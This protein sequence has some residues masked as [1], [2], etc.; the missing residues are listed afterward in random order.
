MYNN[1]QKENISK[2]LIALKNTYKEKQIDVAEAV[3]IPESTYSEYIN[4]KREPTKENISKLAKHY[5]VSEDS[6]VDTDLTIIFENNSMYDILNQIFNNAK[7]LFPIIEVECIDDPLFLKAKE[8]HNK[9]LML[10][11]N[12]VK[13]VDVI[14]L[15]FDSYEKYNN[16]DS[17]ANILMLLLI[18]K[19]NMLM[20]NDIELFTDMYDIFDKHEL[21][22]II[23]DAI[24]K[25]FD[26]DFDKSDF[27]NDN[28]LLLDKIDTL[29]N[30][31]FDD[32]VK[33]DIYREFLEYYLM[34]QY[35]LGIGNTD[36]S[37][38][39]NGLIAGEM[40]QNLALLNNSYINLLINE[41]NKILK[42]D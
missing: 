23:K 6:L 21:E 42:F 30:N 16:H 26:E 29:T 13:I 8:L 35:L 11:D 7:L 18:E 9:L 12:S 4:L 32:L 40:I 36:L 14:R 2:N 5:H 41:M 31:I 22:L 24:L 19:S 27:N 10:H 3:G 17:Y 20:D 1:K 38:E 39:I 25:R 15:Y 37:L 34:L 33:I 28:Q